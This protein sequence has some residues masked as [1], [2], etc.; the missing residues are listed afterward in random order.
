MAGYIEVVPCPLSD[1][2]FNE[3]LD[4]TERYKVQGWHNPAET[5]VWWHY[6]STSSSD[7]IDSYIVLN[8]GLG[9]WYAGRA[10][11]NCATYA[12]G[13]TAIGYGPSGDA[14]LAFRSPENIS[15]TNNTFDSDTDWEKGTNWQIGSGV[16]NQSAPTSSFIWTSS[17]SSMTSGA[18]YTIQ[19]DVTN[20]TAGGFSAFMSTGPS[21]LGDVVSSGAITVSSATE[22]VTGILKAP[23]ASCYVGIQADGTFDGDI[24]NVYV[25]A[26]PIVDWD[27]SFVSSSSSFTREDI[28]PFAETGPFELGSGENRVHVT[29]LFPDTQDSGEL[30]FTF[31][32]REYPTSSETTYGPYTA[33]N[34]TSVRFS[35]RQFKVRVEPV[36]ASADWRSGLHRLEITKGGER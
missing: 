34:P 14:V 9:V 16:A 10:P 22:T 29:K 25:Y 4:V 31:K 20:W 33:A 2:F 24:D 8:Y 5:E 13:V 17:A 6:Q 30:D 32:T 28:T 3:D 19:V 15:I 12:P 36:D 21:G 26:T 18:Y 11:F 23:G 35:G 27:T 1:W 7:D